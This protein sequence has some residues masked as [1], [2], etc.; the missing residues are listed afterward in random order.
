M[1]Q[2]WFEKAVARIEAAFNPERA[3]PGQTVVWTLT[4]QLRDGYYTYPTRQ[5]DPA[6]ASLINQIRFPEPGSVIFV[7]TLQD[8]SPVHIRAEPELGIAKLRYCTGTVVY[9]R[10]AVVHPRAR[11]ASVTVSVPSVRLNICDK[12]NCFPVKELS[13]TAPLTIVDGPPVPVEAAYQEEVK[14][15]LDK[16][17]PNS[18][19][20]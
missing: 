14:R 9:A 3:R 11:P 15:V 7:G 17:G 1:T 8:R 10:P 5:S 6:A 20:R 2:K 13:V 19:D 16:A 4:I 18:A 12:N